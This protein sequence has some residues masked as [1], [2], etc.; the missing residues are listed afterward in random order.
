MDAGAPILE[1]DPAPTAVVE[2]HRVIAG[3]GSPDRVVLCFF[4]SVIDRIKASG[5]PVLFELEAAHGV[6]PVYG[7]EVD[8]Q[9]IA[10]FHP[11]VGAPLAGA[12]FEEAIWDKLIWHDRPSLFGTSAELVASLAESW[13]VP[14]LAVPQATH[15]VLDTVIWR[16]KGATSAQA[17]QAV[18]DRFLGRTGRSKYF[19][20]IL[21]LGRT[22]GFGGIVS[23]SRLCN[24][25]A[26]RE[27]R[28]DHDER[29]CV[30]RDFHV[31]NRH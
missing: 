15:C 25:T 28:E 11:G 21:L 1:F 27:C 18:R 19:D 22:V 12:F 7:I 17:A 4:R 6:H 26:E 5:A 14:L 24:G 23:P 3:S 9:K 8:G 16:R 2:P 20:K 31:F 30:S 10:V 29:S 13:L